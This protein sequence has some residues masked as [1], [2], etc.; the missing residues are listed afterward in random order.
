MSIINDRNI[1]DLARLNSDFWSG[2]ILRGNDGYPYTKDG[3]YYY[4]AGGLNSY[5]KATAIEFYGVNSQT[6]FLTIF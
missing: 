5:F 4:I 2:N 1:S 3:I 6:N